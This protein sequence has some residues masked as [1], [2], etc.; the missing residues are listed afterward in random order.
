VWRLLDERE[1]LWNIVLHTKY[2]EEGGGCGLVML[3]DRFD[4]TL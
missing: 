2:S 3:V 4:G 1:T